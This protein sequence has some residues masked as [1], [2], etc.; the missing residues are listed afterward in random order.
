M[1]PCAYSQE[2]LG[3]YLAR[4]PDRRLPALSSLHGIPLIEA[5]MTV[6][7]RKKRRIDSYLLAMTNKV[8]DNVLDFDRA[9]ALELRSSSPICRRLSICACSKAVSASKAVASCSVARPCPVPSGNTRDSEAG[10]S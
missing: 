6:G 4:P 7:R 9:T 2:R 5:K 3:A 1:Q 8:A 10:E